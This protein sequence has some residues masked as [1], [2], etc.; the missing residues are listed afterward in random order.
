M[1]S[2]QPRRLNLPS[3]HRSRGERHCLSGRWRLLWL[4]LGVLLIAAAA[5][6]ESSSALGKYHQGRTLHL[7]VVSIDRVPEVRY[8][9]IDPEEVVR[10]WRLAP[11]ANGTELVLVRM[12]VENHTAVSAIVN[13][14]RGA[15]EMRDFSNG[16]YFPLSISDSVYQDLRG[17]SQVPIR[18]D[19]G[20][21]F[22]PNRL[23]VDTGTELQWNNEGVVEHFI[24]FDGAEV[25]LQGT[26]RAA[27]SPN[28]SVSHTFSQPGVFEYTC[29]AADTLPA[30][31]E[32]LVADKGSGSNVRERPLLFLEGPFELPQGTQIDGWMIFE[33]PIGT[34]F[35]DLRGRAGDS[36]TVRF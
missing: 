32:V 3:L 26:G 24:E 15:A 29:G 2:N 31:A 13:V 7:N 19:L 4:A 16:S 5:C 10:H 36:I 27:I 18:M 25:P 35:R 20:Q 11:S 1:T 12:K 33:V 30:A 14:D 34:E 6:S 8:S 9:T 28:G 23:L 17:E 22:D 21:C